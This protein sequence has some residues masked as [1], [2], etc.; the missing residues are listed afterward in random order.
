MFNTRL[1]Y[2]SVSKNPDTVTAVTQV[3]LFAFLV[4]HFILSNSLRKKWYKKKF[5]Y[6]LCEILLRVIVVLL[7]LIINK[8]C[9]S[10]Q[11]LI[12]KT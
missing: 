3:Q 11:V 12:R 4:N 2:N 7:K 10:Q 5:K 8:I 6:F 9:Q 1:S